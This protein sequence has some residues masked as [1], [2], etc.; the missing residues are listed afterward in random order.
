MRIVSKEFEAASGTV[1]GT[2]T[3]FNLRER[4]GRFFVIQCD[5]FNAGV[6]T[7]TV[8]KDKLKLS[9]KSNLNLLNINMLNNRV[10]DWSRSD[11]NSNECDVF[12][13][14]V[15]LGVK[16]LVIIYAIVEDN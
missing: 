1:S 6:W 5:L 9:N 12:I 7:S 11:A 16:T 2:F 3:K 10:E 13:D 14:T 4:N 8:T 15:T